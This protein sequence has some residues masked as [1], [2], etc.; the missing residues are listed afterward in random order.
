[1]NNLGHSLFAVLVFALSFSFCQSKKAKNEI[2]SRVIERYKPVGRVLEKYITQNKVSGGV[3]LVYEK[4]E[5]VF[6]K[7]FGN[8]DVEKQEPQQLNDIFRIASMTKPITSVAAMMLF[9]E[10]KFELDD[11]VSKYIPA[12]EKLQ[13]LKFVNRKDSSFVAHPATETMTIRQLFT[14]T[15]GLYYAYDNDS[16]SLLFAKAGISEGFEE[17][18]ILLADNVKKLATLPLLHEPGERYHYGLEMDVLGRLVEVWS[19][20]SLDKF[21]SQ[22]IF[23]PLGMKDTYFYPPE[24]K[25]DRLVP[26]YMSSDNGVERTDYPFVHYPV[27]GAKKFLSGGADLSSTAYDYFLFCKMMLQK[28]QLNGEKILAPETVELISSTH[29]ETGDNDMGLGFGLLSAKTEVDLARSVGSI[30]WGGFFTTTFWI[31]PAEEVIAILMLQMYPFDHWDIQ[32]DFENE[33]YKA[34]KE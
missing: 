22:R 29:L 3:G 26:V 34:V 32:K 15:S 23:Q 10:G 14:F 19:G 11:P 31:D 17:R 4:G 13:V 33:I 30:S 28:G 5:L 16:L 18:N 2:E 9:D 20:M 6:H 25:H 12:F 1:M 24:N 21:L 7:A 27:R 8:R